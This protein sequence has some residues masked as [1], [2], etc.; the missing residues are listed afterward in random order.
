MRR[1]AGAATQPAHSPAGNTVSYPPTRV[2]GALALHV[3]VALRCAQ[4]QVAPP[5]CQL[6]GAAGRAG[7]GR[8][9]G[10]AAVAET[11]SAGPPITSLQ[12]ECAATCRLACLPLPCT[13]RRLC[14]PARPP[15][16]WAHPSTAPPPPHLATSTCHRRPPATQL[17]AQSDLSPSRASSS[18]SGSKV[19]TY[20]STAGRGGAAGGAVGTVAGHLGAGLQDKSLLRR[21]HAGFG[22]GDAPGRQRTAGMA[23]AGSRRLLTRGEGERDLLRDVAR[24]RR[25]AGCVPQ[26]PAQHLPLKPGEGRGGGAGCG[27]AA[28]VAKRARQHGRWS[29]RLLCCW[30]SAMLLPTPTCQACAQGPAGCGAWPGW[31]GGMR[32]AAQ[33]PCRRRHPPPPPGPQR[34]ASCCPACGSWPGSRRCLGGAARA[35]SEH[36]A[37]WCVP[38]RAQRPGGPGIAWSMPPRC[39]HA[40]SRLARRR[41][42]A[43]RRHSDRRALP[44]LLLLMARR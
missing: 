36:T 11:L 41:A 18:T 34:P 7:R 30:Q 27:A 9:G 16:P 28:G 23:A 26:P 4:P 5:V 37:R 14:C 32:W 8:G 13:R 29:Q 33:A 19:H 17:S 12:P 31:A 2:G 24:P 39:L 38:Y 21:L 42:L 25:L 22:S 6:L 40:R 1:A 10:G 44:S 43:T 35:G 20:S 3:E 15:L